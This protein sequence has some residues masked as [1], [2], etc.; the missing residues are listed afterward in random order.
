MYLKIQSISK[1]VLNVQWSLQ[2]LYRFMH[3]KEP[4][5]IC[6]EHPIL[7]VVHGSNYILNRRFIV[8]IDIKRVIFKYAVQYHLNLLKYLKLCMIN[9]N[10]N[11]DIT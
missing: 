7:C 4:L 9:S 6:F 8:M 2:W 11:K 10:N 1:C 5:I 3:I